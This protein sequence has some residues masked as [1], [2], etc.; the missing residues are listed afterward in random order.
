MASLQHPV[1]SFHKLFLHI[2][3]GKRVVKI[4]VGQLIFNGPQIRIRC[5]RRVWYPPY[6]PYVQRAQLKIEQPVALE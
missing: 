4:N 6:A 3:R 5:H 1:D 2:I